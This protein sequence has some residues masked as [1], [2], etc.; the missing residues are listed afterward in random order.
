NNIRRVA[1]ERAKLETHLTSDF[2]HI[3]A[4]ACRVLVEFIYDTIERGRRRALREMLSLCEDAA[5]GDTDRVVRERL[6]RYLETTYSR[7]IEDIIGETGRY[8]KLMRL[9]AGRIDSTD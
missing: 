8:D 1:T 5:H 7:E 2:N 3:V 6:L 9:V 4:A